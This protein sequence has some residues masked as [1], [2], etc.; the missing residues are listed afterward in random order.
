[1]VNNE[2]ELIGL[3]TL[4]PSQ[5]V[6]YSTCSVEN[7]VD[8]FLLTSTLKTTRYQTASQQLVNTPWS[9]IFKPDFEYFPNGISKNRQKNVLG[10]K[11]Q[12]SISL[13]SRI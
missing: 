11:G 1:M 3:D 12:M 7:E 4:N 8:E 6:C 5:L 10:S 2:L 13:I 9:N